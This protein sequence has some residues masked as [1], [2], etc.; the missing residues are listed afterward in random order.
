VTKAL[1]ELYAAY[2]RLA[3]RYKLVDKSDTFETLV[4]ANGARHSPVQRWFYL[5]EAFSLDL[6][7]GVIRDLKTL[8]PQSSAPTR[9]LDAF[10]GG[11]TSLLSCQM[12]ARTAVRKPTGVVGVEQN[13]FL[14]FVSKTKTQWHTYDRTRF[15]RIA[16]RLLSRTPSLDDVEI[17]ELS[18]LRRTDVFA[19]RDVRLLL[20]YRQMIRAVRSPE[21]DL[22]RLGL[23]AAIE[24]VSKVRKDGRALR[25]VPDKQREDVRS[26]LERE[27]LRIADDLLVAKEWFRPIDSRVV[28]GDGRNLNG[29]IP[30]ARR[31]DLAIYSPPYPN[32]IDYTEV[33]KLEL[34]LG[35]FLSTSK[36][37]R[38][39]RHL[40]VRSHPS[41]R[42]TCPVTLQKDA[43]MENVRATLTLLLRALPRNRARTLG[44]TVFEGYFDDMLQSLES[45]RARLAPNGWIVCNVGNSL[46]GPQKLKR[47]RI[48]VAA[49][50]IIAQIADAIGLEVFPIRIARHLGRRGTNARHLR[51]SILVMR[52]KPKSV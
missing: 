14:Q 33:Y 18:T 20:A 10:C 42:F 45:Q 19:R 24:A 34:W 1:A 41:V 51:E 9:V 36:Q 2:D 7:D 15:L 47:R 8:A 35:G 3:R 50:L 29:D 23:T 30:K 44:R 46:H 12:M 25:I 21:R 39:L 22:L 49:D 40:T 28:F 11:G 48:P 52:E 26:A 43:R 5:K 38:S 32:N 6:L 13:P 37:F 31:F 16:R 4:R 27:W 17:P